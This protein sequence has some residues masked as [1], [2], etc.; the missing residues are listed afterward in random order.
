MTDDQTPDPTPPVAAGS[1]GRARYAARSKRNRTW[2]IVISVVV[3]LLVGAGVALAVTS[4]TKKKAAPVVAP[5]TTTTAVPSVCPLTGAPAPAGAVPSRPALAVKVDNYPAA[6][7]QSGLNQADIVFEEPVEGRITRLAAVF[8]C[9]SPAQVGDIRSARAPDV[10]IA[11]LLSHPL[12]VHAGGISPVISLLESANLVNVDVF[13]HGSL[14]EHPSGRSAPYSTY[15]SPAAVWALYPSATTP[16]APVF[17]YSPAPIGG[18]PAASVHI[19]FSSTNDTTWTWEAA[20]SAWA[21]SYAG[22]SATVITGD[23]I[24]TSNVVV[25]SVGV[26]YGPWAENNLGGL[27]VQAQ[28]TGSGPVTVLRSGQQITGTWSRPSLGAPMTLTSATGATIALQ[29]GQSWVEVV[30]TN[31]TVTVA[32]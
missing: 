19:P 8:Q 21:L 7:P 9:Q 25:M 3:A 1:R 20:K 27:E 24:T 11:D 16:P 28:M 23:P 18:T 12:L 10:P 15:A 30:P 32:P 26:T 6:R 2:V 14:V 17:T 29:P 4:A 13:T 31:V 5:D 22:V